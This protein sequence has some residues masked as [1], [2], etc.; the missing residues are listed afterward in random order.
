MFVV[1]QPRNGIR[2]K[3][4]VAEPGDLFHHRRAFSIETYDKIGIVEDLCDALPM[5]LVNLVL[6][7]L[8]DKFR[9]A[10]K[11]FS[12]GRIPA[13]SEHSRKM[14]HPCAASGI[15]RDLKK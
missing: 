14:I 13:L 2:R 8:A 1:L 6:I 5:R 7:A 10:P 15:H 9:V 12:S 11:I 4:E 3:N